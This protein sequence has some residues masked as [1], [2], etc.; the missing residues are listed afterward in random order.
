MRANSEPGLF[1]TVNHLNGAQTPGKIPADPVT[2]TKTSTGSTSRRVPF[3]ERPTCTV[4]EAC[5]AAGLGRTKLY[6]LFKD[7]AIES[8]TVGRRRLVRVP[9]LLKFLGSEKL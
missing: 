9:S 5:G 1:D 2:P 6:E 4:A 7:N 3:A 8:L